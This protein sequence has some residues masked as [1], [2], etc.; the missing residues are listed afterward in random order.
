[1]EIEEF[2]SLLELC[3]GVQMGSNRGRLMWG[4]NEDVRFRVKSVKDKLGETGYSD[5]PLLSFGMHGY[6]KNVCIWRVGLE[7]LLTLVDLAK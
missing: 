1:M 3:E 6:Q 7:R 4:L 2:G 5:R